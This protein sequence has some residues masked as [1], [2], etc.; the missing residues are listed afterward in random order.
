MNHGRTL[1]ST[2][3]LLSLSFLAG[4]GD[5]GN[6]Q[7]STPAVVDALAPPDVGTQFSSTE[8]SLEPGEERFFCWSVEL[9][10]ALAMVGLKTQLP[11]SAHHYTVFL[12][13]DTIEQKGPYDCTAPN[14]NWSPL[15]GGGIGTQDMQFPEGRAMT[16]KKG[17]HIILQLH[18]LNTSSTTVTIPSG[19]LNLLGTEKV[20]F[21]EV[22]VLVAG[23]FNVAIPPYA[24]DATVSGGCT[25]P[26][27]AKDMFGAYPHMHRL[28]KR[29]EIRVQHQGGGSTTVL[30]KAWSFNE[31][32]VYQTAGSAMAG[33]Q[34]SVTC[35]Y[36]NPTPNQV[37]FDLTTA[38]EMCL[39]IIY[40]S[41]A[42]EP[43][44]YCLTQ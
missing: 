4:C 21:E 27:A 32:P 18:L 23:T 10:Q 7:E 11:P 12:S 14:L 40:Y 20:G 31:Q 43:S 5:A 15:L 28:G 2:L 33:D 1:S 8:V 35:Y 34:V 38:G 19:Q 13:P 41:P 29:A 24:K 3:V 42:Q 39:A 37:V 22:G 44:T 9:P 17:A 6:L 26:T 25:L 16:L 30:D 36:D